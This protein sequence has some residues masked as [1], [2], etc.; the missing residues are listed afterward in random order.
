MDQSLIMAMA[1]AFAL[2]GAGCRHEPS[3]AVVQGRAEVTVARAAVGRAEQA[4]HEAEGAVGPA[5]AGVAAAQQGQA[6]QQARCQAA[7]RAWRVA[8]AEFARVRQAFQ[9]RTEQPCCQQGQSPE[10]DRAM[11]ASHARS[12]EIAQACNE[13]ATRAAVEVMNAQGRLGGAEQRVEV[14]RGDVERARAALAA[15][16][17]RLRALEQAA[18]S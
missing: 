18:G 2:I 16:E 7:N 5:R 13:P 17:E 12:V 10:T 4:L 8:D 14:A 15:Q 11:A 9:Q 3:P 6:D 1:F